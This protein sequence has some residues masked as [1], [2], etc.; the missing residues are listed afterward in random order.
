MALRTTHCKILFVCFVRVL[1]GAEPWVRSMSSI[2]QVVY[3]SV[4]PDSKNIGARAAAMPQHLVPQTIPS[5][6]SHKP[7]QVARGGLGKVR[8]C[9][10]DICSG[11]AHYFSQEPSLP[12]LPICTEAI[13]INAT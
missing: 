6:D 13:D 3:T 11:E 10:S 4:V 12:V 7:V 1:G 9:I 5:H 2:T 8:E